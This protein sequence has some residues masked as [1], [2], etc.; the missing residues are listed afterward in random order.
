MNRLVIIAALG[1][2]G[3][4]CAKH[5]ATEREP[6]AREAPLRPLPKERPAIDPRSSEAA[7][8][9][10]QGFVRLVNAG[11]LNDAYMLLGANAPPRADFDRR[12]ARYSGLRATSGTA[13]AQDAAAGSIYVSVPITL[14]GKI[15]GKDVR[16]HGS[17]V[18][19]RVNNVPGSSEMQRR[20]HI[21]RIDWEKS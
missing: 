20:W 12:F 13:G 16:D 3:G 15:N 11:R 10:V 8:N 21:E 6:P 5:E 9:L 18:L 4:A 19:R 2:A 14:A 17:A 1:F 7:E